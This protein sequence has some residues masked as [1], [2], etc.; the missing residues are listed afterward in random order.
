MHPGERVERGQVIGTVGMTG[1]TTGAHLHYEVHVGGTPADP[2]RW[3][4]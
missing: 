1:S 3:L 2:R 4:R